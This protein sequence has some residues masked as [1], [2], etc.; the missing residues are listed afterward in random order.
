MRATLAD[1]SLARYAG[2]LVW[3][4]LDFDK[5][6]NQAFLAHHGVTYTPSF[7]VLDPADGRATATQFGGMTL[8]EL[9][10]FLERGE[11]GVLAKAKTPADQALARGDAMLGHGQRA[12]AIAAYR[13]ALQLGGAS[14]PERDRAVGALT[15][16][17]MSNGQAQPC[18]EAATAEA[19]HM[20]RGEAFGRVVLAG[21]SC[22]Q[23]ESGPWAEAT[24]K[25]LE[26]LAVEAI[27]IPGVLRD[28]RF[29][30]YQVLMSNA[31]ARSDKAAVAR[32]GNRWLD[33]LD[34]TKPA[35]DDERSALDI[36]RVDAA[37]IME[38]PSRVLPAL[39]ASE[40]A[41]PNNYNASLRVA[42]MAS[43]AKHYDEAIAACDRGLVH[44]TGPLGRS[45]LLQVKADALIGKGQRNEAHRVLEE[46]LRSAQAIGVSQI[47]EHNLQRI[48]NA[49][50]ESEMSK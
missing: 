48:S 5:P 31:Q 8:P 15:W 38:D 28:H 11:R 25:I 33:E 14:W 45:W 26:P 32:W 22:T 18:A 16:T 44:V 17:L 2:R 27:A 23:G 36:A 37:S 12:E 39:T 49:L 20:I 43:E 19:P 30:L 40:K 47:R 24:R 46:A 21:L 1:A 4:E 35:N 10:R 13:E 41:M 50:K 9:T 29:Q 6:G 7:F 42:Q 3:L 34:A